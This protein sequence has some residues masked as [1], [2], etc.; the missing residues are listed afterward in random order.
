M[1]DLWYFHFYIYCLNIKYD[2]YFSATIDNSQKTE[3]KTYSNQYQF[4]ENK[5]K[6][7]KFTTKCSIIEK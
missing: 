3:M 7:S 1:I 5:K 4:Q 6:V 2:N